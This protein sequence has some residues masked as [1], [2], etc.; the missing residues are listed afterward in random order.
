M[1]KQFKE[2][3]MGIPTSKK[4]SYIS[5][6]FE[7]IPIED[8]TKLICTSVIPEKDTSEEIDFDD[9]GDIDGGKWDVDF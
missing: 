9:K 3:W 4:A 6:K 1:N 7:M 8:T 5:P 2:K